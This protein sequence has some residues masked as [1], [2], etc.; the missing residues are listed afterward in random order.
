MKLPEPQIDRNSAMRLW[1]KERSEYAKEQ[2]VLNNVG[3]VGL[4]LKSLHVNPV[5]EDLFATGL[6]GVIKSVN[7]YNPQNE[8]QFTSYASTVIRNEIIMLLRK[9]HALSYCSIDEPLVSENGDHLYFYEVIED[10]KCMEDEVVAKTHMENVFRTLK[11]RDRKVI[12]MLASGM[13]Q[14]EIAQKVGITQSMVSKIVSKV[15]TKV[16]N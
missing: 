3:M 5:D 16:R 8:V 7:T 6:V 13:E 12:E 9:R 1:I 14:R 15:K 4:V 10:K 11:E 2:V